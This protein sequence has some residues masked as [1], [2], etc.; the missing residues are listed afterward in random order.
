MNVSFVNVSL[1]TV[2]Y[3]HVSQSIDQSSDQSVNQST[4]QSIDQSVNRSTEWSISQSI[5]RCAHN[6]SRTLHCPRDTETE[7]AVA[8]HCSWKARAPP[9]RDTHFV[10]RRQRRSRRWCG[11]SDEDN[12]AF[13]NWMQLLMKMPRLCTMHNNCFVYGALY[14]LCAKIYLLHKR[15]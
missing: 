10:R 11:R 15:Y 8:L 5:Y 1:W 9:R 12:V 7:S 6:L 13:I 2:H 14:S 3:M 4:N